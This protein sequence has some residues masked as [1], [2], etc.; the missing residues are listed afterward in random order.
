MSGYTGFSGDNNLS[1]DCGGPGDAHLG[2]H[3]GMVSNGYI[4]GD[5]HLVVGF[6]TVSDPGNPQGSPVNGVACP[7]LGMISDDDMARMGE[8]KM[9]APILDKPV[10]V[11]PDHGTG[12]NDDMAS[13]AGSVHQ[14]DIGFDD[15]MVFD[16]TSPADE[17]M[18]HDLDMAAD[19]CILF[20]HHVGGNGD[21]FSQYAV[22]SDHCQR[23]DAG[24]RCRHRVKLR[25]QFE[26]SPSGIVGLY[27]AGMGRRIWNLIRF[28]NDH[29]PGTGL[30]QAGQKRGLCGKGN[31]RCGCMV[32]GRDPGDH[33]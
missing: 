26:K 13:Q 21:I 22:I 24:N 9:A 11:G 3:Q 16:Y 12:V 15:G 27:K 23:A 31:V 5:V 28:G 6:H 30:V 10:S 14:C 19:H 25:H 33:R 32:Q 8:F 4:V 2:H 17:D 20:N 18:G 29:S 1:A 7:D